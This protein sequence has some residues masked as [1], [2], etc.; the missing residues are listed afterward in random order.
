MKGL[1]K[2]FDTF[3]SLVKFSKDEKG[4]EEL[5]KDLVNFE[6]D[7]RNKSKWNQSESALYSGARQP[8]VKCF[9]C[10]QIGHKMSVCKREENGRGPTRSVICYKCHEKG[11]IAKDCKVDE[12]RNQVDQ[13]QMRIKTQ[14]K[15]FQCIWC[16]RAGHTEEF[17][18]EKKRREKVN[19]VENKEQ[20]GDQTDEEFSFFTYDMDLED[21]RVF[22]IDS[23]CSNYMIKDR[24]LF[25]SLDE[26]Y[27][28]AYECANN[29]SSKIEGI[30]TVEIF[31]QQKDGR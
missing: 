4:L 10:H 17:C 28:G 18:Y 22:V 13:A 1:P 11:H 19:F 14:E 8:I 24:D 30:G 15:R 27:S 7:K 21:Q 31:A 20:V 2:E 23:G 16:K 25:T 5:K 29:S 9:K 3:V 6:S 12:K 26:T